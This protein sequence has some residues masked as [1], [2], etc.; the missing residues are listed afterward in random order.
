MLHQFNLG[1]FEGIQVRVEEVN[2]KQPPSKKRYPNYF[3][4]TL[5]AADNPCHFSSVT[6]LFRH[7]N[8]RGKPTKKHTKVT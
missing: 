8:Q 5:K 2:Y 3:R 1:Q 4:F 6:G 7:N